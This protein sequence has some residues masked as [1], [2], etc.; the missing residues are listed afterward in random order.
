MRK[1]YIVNDFFD[2][3]LGLIGHIVFIIF[4][5]HKKIKFIQMKFCQ[6][7]QCNDFFEMT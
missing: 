4:E 5:R 1:L 6:T 2:N 7:L 3:N